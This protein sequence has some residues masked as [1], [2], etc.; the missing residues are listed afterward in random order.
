MMLFSENLLSLKSQKFACREGGIF[1]N[2]IKCVDGSNRHYLSYGAAHCNVSG[3][4]HDGVVRV[5]RSRSPCHS[6]REFYESRSIVER[7]ANHR[8]ILPPRWPSW[9]SRRRSSSQTLGTWSRRTSR[10]TAWSS[11]NSEFW[12]GV[13]LPNYRLVQLYLTPEVFKY[14]TF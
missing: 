8:V 9:R 12:N 4:A 13:D 3:P 10:G 11:L 14:S 7:G 6:K 2:T 5:R 1:S